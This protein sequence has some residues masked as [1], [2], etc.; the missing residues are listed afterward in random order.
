MVISELETEKEDNLVASLEV[1]NTGA[2]YGGTVIQIYGVIESPAAQHPL[3]SLVA[4]Q[5]IHLTPG[6]TKKV[7]L[8]IALRDM[9]YF[10]GELREWAL[11]AGRYVFY[12]GNSASDILQTVNLTLERRQYKTDINRSIRR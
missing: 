1:S 12:L 9:A 4:F 7:K 10:D 8:S 6:E 5:K 2:V 11:D 3:K